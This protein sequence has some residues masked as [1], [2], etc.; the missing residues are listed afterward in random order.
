MRAFCRCI[1]CRKR[2]A[3]CAAG[4]ALCALLALAGTV[5]AALRPASPLPVIMYHSVVTD[6]AG[7]GMY[8]VTAQTLEED[9]RFLRRAGCVSLTAGEAAALAEKGEPL[10][11]NSVV[12][13]FDDGYLNC[14]TEALPLLERY[15][16]KATVAVIGS[17]CETY[18]ETP[19]PNPAYACLD[20]EQI[21]ALA[22]SG[23]IEIAAHSYA[24]HSL[25]PRK[26]ASRRKGESEAAY[27]EALRADTEKVLTLLEENC[28][29]RP[30]TYV[31]PYGA[32]SGE[33]FP[34]LRA[35][36]FTAALTCREE[37]N[38]VAGTDGLLVLGRFNRPSG[39]STAAFMEKI[40]ICG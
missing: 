35:A 7:A 39:V 26:G 15:D 19:D 30:T 32:V 27:R 5:R 16:L 29:L 38:R 34:V 10:P 36:G 20:W 4:A 3:F 31:Y 18:A 40:G 12:I 9:F 25:W 2:V 11:E 22:Q 23:R 33:S 21:G 13:T 8:A 37:V 28:G 24:M 17:C 6:P 14:L 1:V